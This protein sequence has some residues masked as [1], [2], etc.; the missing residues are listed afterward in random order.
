M[1]MNCR[2][3]LFSLPSGVRY[4][5]HGYMSP[6][7]R[8]V[9]AAGEAAIRRLS[10]PSEIGPEDFFRD[11][12][13]ARRLFARLINAS[14]PLRVAIVPATSYAFSQVARNTP[15]KKG[16][17]VVMVG[18]EFP[19]N[20]YV[21]KRACDQSGARL[22]QIVPPCEGPA[23]EAKWNNAILEAIGRQTAVVTLSSV[24]WTDGAIFDLERIG[25]RAREVGAAFLV[26]GTQSVGA[27]PFDVQRIRPDA[28]ICASYKWLTA[29]YSIGVAYFGERYDEGVP[30]EETWLVR[31]G[32][33]DFAGLANYTERYRPGAIRYDVGETSN[34]VLAP[35]LVAALRQVLDW[36]A[37]AVAEYAAALTRNLIGEARSR[38]FTVADDRWRSD[39]LFGLR[40]PEGTDPEQ[41][42]ARLQEK[43]IQVSVRG[44]AVRISAHLYNDDA[45]VKAL[46]DALMS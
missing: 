8:Q 2:K 14:D 30:I 33:D 44:E 25:S 43:R 15:L 1:L 9:A 21:W 31:E 16:Q 38:G 4:L 24:H 13:E 12:N 23:R 27:L 40:M 7:S 46:R 11:C 41:L 28:L 35:M 36:G 42:R 6:L 17:S 29:P 39:H 20:Y 19:S 10:N 3:E 22:R 32:S 34:F 26:D 45:D 18:Q 37:G 5:N